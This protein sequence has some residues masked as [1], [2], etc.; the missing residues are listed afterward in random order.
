MGLE[1]ELYSHAAGKGIT[2]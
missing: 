1:K 2:L